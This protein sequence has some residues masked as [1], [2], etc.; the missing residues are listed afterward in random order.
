MDN[1][2][3]KKDNGEQLSEIQAEVVTDSTEIKKEQAKKVSDAQNVILSYLHDLVFLLVGLLVLFVLLFRIVVVSGDSMLNTLHEGD[4]LVVLSSSVYKNPKPGDVVV[5][6]KD[7]Y[8]DGEPLVKRVIAV[9]GQTIDIKQGVVYVDG[10][11]QEGEFTHEG[12]VGES[13]Q[14]YPMT[15]PDGYIFVLGDNRNNSTDSR[16]N[17]IG[18]ISE[19]EVLGKVLFIAL[20]SKDPV[21][22]RR[23]FSRFGAV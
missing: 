7:A 17:K 18:L 20:P 3:N 21:T 10:V 5:V 12:Y 15:I 14:S 6:S 19:R 13:A 8:K 1:I 11:E 9:G 4:Y 2:E 22:D 23:D 16:S